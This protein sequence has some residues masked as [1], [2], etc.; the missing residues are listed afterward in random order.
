MLY[1]ISRT[2]IY[3]IWCHHKYLLSPCGELCARHRSTMMDKRGIMPLNCGTQIT[4]NIETI[5]IVECQ[6]PGAEGWGT[7]HM[8]VKGCKFPSA[9]GISSGDKSTAWWRWLATLYFTLESCHDSRALMFSPWQQQN[10]NY[11]RWVMC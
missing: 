8:L 5:E 7:W 1:L 4:K 11:I 2:F 3:S 10:G 9:R 6:L